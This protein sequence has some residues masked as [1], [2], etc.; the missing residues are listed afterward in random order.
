MGKNEL[1]KGTLAEEALT[2]FD[3]IFHLEHEFAEMNPENRYKA[4]L[5]QTK[6]LLEAF[7]TWL[8]TTQKKVTAKSGLGTAIFYTLNQWEF[9]VSFLKDGRLEITNNWAERAIKEFVI[10]RKNFL[11]STSVKGVVAS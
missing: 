4:R 9:L 2:Y 6:P 8:K 3:R 1:I 10:G 5:E 7:W 11:F